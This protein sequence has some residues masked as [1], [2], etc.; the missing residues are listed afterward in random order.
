MQ[1]VN[2]L[3]NGHIFGTSDAERRNGFFFF[4]GQNKAEIHKTPN[5]E[6]PNF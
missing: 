2:H 1:A 6:Y 4:F 3:Q 5:R